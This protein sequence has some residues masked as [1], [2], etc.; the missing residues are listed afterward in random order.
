MMM[1]R[2]IINR[3]RI[4]SRLIAFSIGDG[5]LSS[6][7]RSIASRNAGVGSELVGTFGESKETKGTFVSI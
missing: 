1:T 4:V 5:K 7:G 2:K 6:K 3:T